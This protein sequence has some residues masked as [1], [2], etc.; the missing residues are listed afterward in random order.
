MNIFLKIKNWLNKIPP[1][2]QVHISVVFICGFFLIFG[3]VGIKYA[4]GNI[5][6]NLV[7]YEEPEGYSQIDIPP[8]KSRA[9]EENQSSEN[10][11]NSGGQNQKKNTSTN[12]SGLSGSSGAG[13]Y[14]GPNGSSQTQNQNISTDPIIHSNSSS[15]AYVNNLRSQV[16]AGILTEDSVLNQ[17]AKNYALYLANNCL[18]LTHQDLNPFLG[19]KLGNGAT[20]TAYAENLATAW[21]YSDN[22]SQMLNMLKDSPSHYANMV[23]SQMQYIGISIVE[24]GNVNCKDHFYMV[25]HFAKG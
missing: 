20:I 12:S 11:E 21:G 23:S 25:Q 7:P 1:K 8:E 18:D 13:T 4:G 24:S 3:A 2:Y 14:N 22:I 17:N 9:T 5:M 6:R 10:E 19:S 15:I 16:G